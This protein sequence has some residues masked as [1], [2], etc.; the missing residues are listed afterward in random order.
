M[1]VISKKEIEEIKN[2]NFHDAKISKIVCDYDEG[3]VE[4]PIIMDDTHQYAALLN[5]KDVMYVKIDRKEPWGPGCYI[6][7]LD[8]EDAKGD[9][10][11][12]SILLN[13]GDEVIIVALKMIYSVK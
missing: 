6:S 11:K 4:M 7:T 9:C 12:V 8:V 3:T 1:I 13:S 5:F 10:F 2:I